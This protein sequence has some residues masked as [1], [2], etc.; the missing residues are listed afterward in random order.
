MR[1]GT[2]PGL[3]LAGEPVDDPWADPLALA[4]AAGARPRF[5]PPGGNDREPQDAAPAGAAGGSDR[6]EVG[7]SPAT[8]PAAVALSVRGPD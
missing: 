1:L 8:A 4:R 6:P 5:Q 7:A 2:L 3:A